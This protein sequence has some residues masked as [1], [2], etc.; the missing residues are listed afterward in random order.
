MH[1]TGS[2]SLCTYHL[3]IYL[4][5]NCDNRNPVIYVD[6]VLGHDSH[7]GSVEKPVKTIQKGISLAGPSKPLVLVTVGDYT[8]TVILKNGVTVR[9]S[10]DRNTW[11]CSNTKTSKITGGTYGGYNK[12]GVTGSSIT[13]ADTVIEYFEIQSASSV[14]TPS[15]S[16]SSYGIRC[17][18]CPGL[19]IRNNKI[20]ALAGGTG[21]SG[22]GYTSRALSGTN[23]SNGQRGNCD[24]SAYGELHLLPCPTFG[25]R[26]CGNL[27]SFLVSLCR[28]AT[29]G[30][31]HNVGV[32]PADIP[33]GMA[34]PEAGAEMVKL[35]LITGRTVPPATMERVD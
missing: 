27:F 18:S 16:A 26:S 31:G 22:T 29:E 8:G 34:V 14:P 1:L 11:T 35:A 12:V 25:L 4:G 24:T 9:G 13:Q 32:V 33:L 5:T 23:G 3:G 20:T 30:Q 7:N 17:I 2:T 28:Q 6:G 15:K 21:A 19:V 10:C